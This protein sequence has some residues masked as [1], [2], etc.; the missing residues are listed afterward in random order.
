MFDFCIALHLQQD[1]N[2][3]SKWVIVENSSDTTSVSVAP[4]S[5]PPK[6]QRRHACTCPNCKDG[7]NDRN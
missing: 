4:A 1:P 2:D 5:Q 3:P 6:R 7:N